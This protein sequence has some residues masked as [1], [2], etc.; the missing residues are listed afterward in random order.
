MMKKAE[1]EAAIRRL[2]DVW[3]EARGLPL[4]DGAFH[5]SFLDFKAWLASKGYS[6]YLRF[7]SSTANSDAEHWFDQEM[8]QTWRN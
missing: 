7:R 8:R 5:Y 2:C 6:H 4:P 3:R 1:A